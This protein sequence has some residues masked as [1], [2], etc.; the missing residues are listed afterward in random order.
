MSDSNSVCFVCVC[1]FFPKEAKSCRLPALPAS[2]HHTLGR[3][4]F[5]HLLGCFL[6]KLQLRFWWYVS[7]SREETNNV[8][9]LKVCLLSCETVTKPEN[10]DLFAAFEPSPSLNVCR[11]DNT[12]SYC[13]RH[14]NY[15]T[16]TFIPLRGVTQKWQQTHTEPRKYDLFFVLFCFFLAACLSLQG[17]KAGSKSATVSRLYCLGKMSKNTEGKEGNVINNHV[18]LH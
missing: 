4:H 16:N 1:V 15:N 5:S 13:L 11:H 9:L 10:R 7:T 18:F 17:T 8:S 3:L 2:P 6:K 12:S 14:R